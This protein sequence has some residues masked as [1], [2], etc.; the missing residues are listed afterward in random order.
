M[1]ALLLLV[2]VSPLFGE[3]YYLHVAGLGGEPDYEKRFTQLAMDLSTLTAPTGKTESLTGVQATKQN[4]QAALGRIAAAAKP[5]D[6]FTLTL[7]GHGTWDGTAYKFNIPGPDVA[8]DEL[9]AW[10]DK[11]P[12]RQLIV[13]A[14]SSS[15]AALAALRASN[16]VVITATKSGTE[17]NAVVFSRYWVDGMRDASADADRNDLVTALEAFKFAEQKTV[18]FYES[19][20]RLATEHPLLEDTGKAEGVRTPGPDNGEGLLAGRFPLLRV[21]AAQQAFRDPS[22]QAL[23][24]RKEEL[25][26]QIDRLKYQKASMPI[27]E[28]KKRLQVLLTELA[29]VQEVLDKQ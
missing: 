29:T 25:E 1:K 15:G 3:N 26:E 10:L 16:R 11:I 5:D 7:I 27:D 22:K 13:V 6:T 4:I 23:L 28:Y 14:T 17:K 9:R 18:K 8:A 2:A 19:A 12:A 21:G 24:K 20:D